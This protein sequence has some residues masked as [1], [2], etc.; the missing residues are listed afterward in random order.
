[1]LTVLF[2][3]HLSQTKASANALLTSALAYRNQEYNKLQYAHRELKRGKAGKGEMD[4]LS[5]DNRKLKER[6]R[7]QSEEIKK[8]KGEREA[9]AHV[10]QGN[11]AAVHDKE[12]KHGD[13]AHGTVW[14]GLLPLA[15]T[16]K[17]GP[18]VP[19]FIDPSKQRSSFRTSFLFSA[20]PPL[21]L[22]LFLFRVDAGKSRR[23]VEPT[24]LHRSSSKAMTVSGASGSSPFEAWAALLRRGA[25]R[26]VLGQAAA[27][28]EEESGSRKASERPWIRGGTAVLSW[29]TTLI[30]F[31]PSK[32]TIFLIYISKTLS[33]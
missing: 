24:G 6:I 19:S 27:E 26:I 33:N 32:S 12:D 20:V 16:R 13:G 5:T 3:S 23:Q 10:R 11:A 1:M 7:R 2:L 15:S 4:S 8:L 30:A 14:G 17:P 31:E 18:G 21:T 25:N 9:K 29:S 28:E 22:T